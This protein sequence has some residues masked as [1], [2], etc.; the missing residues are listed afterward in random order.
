MTW[1][2]KQTYRHPYKCFDVDGFRQVACIEWHHTCAQWTN[3]KTFL[4]KNNNNKGHDVVFIVEECSIAQK[5]TVNRVRQRERQGGRKSESH[6]LSTLKWGIC[7]LCINTIPSKCFVN[8][9]IYMLD[10]E[11]IRKCLTFSQ[12]ASGYVSFSTSSSP[13]FSEKQSYPYCLK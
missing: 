7:A 2:I 6:S 12:M 4:P 10:R 1:F 5:H 11:K 13:H 3:K 8:E 9:H